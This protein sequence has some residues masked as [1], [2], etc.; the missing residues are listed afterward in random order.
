MCIRDSNLHWPPAAQ[1][2][3]ER[4]RDGVDRATLDARLGEDEIAGGL[5]PA[6]AQPHVL[7]PRARETLHETRAPA[8]AAARAAGIVGMHVG[9]EAN[10]GGPQRRHVQ[11]HCLPPTR[12]GPLPIGA[13]ARPAGAAQRQDNNIRLYECHGGLRGCEC[14]C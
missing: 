8:A 1:L 14:G 3:R 5:A 9:A 12:L 10:V 6:K 13:E 2:A 11:A 7:Y 4:V